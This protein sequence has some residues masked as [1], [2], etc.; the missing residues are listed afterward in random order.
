M[1]LADA[2]VE[3]GSASEE[4]TYQLQVAWCRTC[5]L[6]QLTDP[7]SPA[8]MFHD[9]YPYTSSIST[10]MMEHFRTLA[11]E[12]IA[13][14]DSTQDPLVV[15][16]G[17]N[18]GILLRH[19][20]ARGL[21]HLGVEPSE[22][23]ARVADAL[24][25][26]TRRA[27][28]CESVAKEVLEEH[29]P[30]EAIVAANVIS[31]IPNLSSALAGVRHLL[32]KTGTFVFEEPYFAAILE[33]TAIDQ[34]YDEHVTY[35]S[36]GAVANCADRHGLSLVDAVA[37]P[38]HGG[39][40]RYTL[41]RAGRRSPSPRVA[42]HLAR[43]AAL[44]LKNETTY[45]AFKERADLRT[46]QF[47]SLLEDLCARGMRIA[48]YGATAKSCTVLNYGGIDARLIQCVYDSTPAKHG[49]LTPGMHIPVKPSR[50]FCKEYPDYAV[51]FAWNHEREIVG[52][53][54]EFVALGGRWIAYVPDV[55]VFPPSL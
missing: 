1:P 47:R 50:D 48:G 37:Q 27:F 33:S 20:A 26:T 21:R 11:T 42:E 19:I 9:A 39:S 43:E 40:M 17:S 52:R 8:R 4:F 45:G 15:E 53:E 2:F 35:L 5:G 28:F 23:V 49:K 54:R 38:T 3:P 44:G 30:A 16:V 24:G 55:R 29:G 6:V 14:L 13:R 51:L 31:H 18:D 25:V 7:V 32:S 22:S 41:Q 36:V 46:R 12:T 34:I 10:V